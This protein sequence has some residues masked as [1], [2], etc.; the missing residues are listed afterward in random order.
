MV[1]L[2]DKTES[3]LDMLKLLILFM[4]LFGTSFFLIDSFA[5]EVEL[6]KESE[7]IIESMGWLE[8]E[9]VSL[10]EQIQ[11]VIDHTN[12]KNKISIGLLSQ[13]LNDIRF[14]DYIEDIIDNPKIISFV[15]SLSISIIAG[16]DF[17]VD[18]VWNGKPN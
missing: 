3:L 12:S 18:S 7:R 5:L 16:E 2:I 1:R 15:P 8:P 9:K 10:Q 14:P 13:N 11:I 17:T 6:Q 4:I